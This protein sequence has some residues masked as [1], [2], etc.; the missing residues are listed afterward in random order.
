MFRTVRPLSRMLLATALAS[1]P[2]AFAAPPSAMRAGPAPVEPICIPWILCH[3][4][5]PAVMTVGGGDGQVIQVKSF[6]WGDS[7]GKPLKLATSDPQ[8]GGEVVARD[9]PRKKV[10]SSVSVNEIPVTKQMD[11]SSPK[12]LSATPSGN[13]HEEE[14]IEFPRVMAAAPAPAPSGTVTILVARNACAS[15]THLPDVKLSARGR[16]YTLSDVDVLSCTAAGA[17]SDSCTLRYS[18]V[19]G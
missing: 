12:V 18:S 8:E 6:A 4:L 3:P 9:A 2:P 11:S 7:A 15:G 5:D 19:S 16:T 13:A 1:A 10:R 14:T 17:D